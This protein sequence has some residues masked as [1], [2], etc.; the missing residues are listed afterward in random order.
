M[1]DVPSQYVSLLQSAASSSGIPYN[2]VAAQI[3]MESG[4][5][6]NAVSP[7][8][9]QGMAQFEPG[10]WSSYGTGSP[11]TPTNAMAAYAK[12]M[13]TL[14]K[15]EGGS[16]RNALAAYNA[17]PGN[18]PAGYGYADSILSAAG[19]SESATASPGSSAAVSN[20]SGG[21]SSSTSQSSLAGDIFNW[22]T[23]PVKGAIGVATSAGDALTAIGKEFVGV[24]KFFDHLVM[25]ETWIRLGAVM[26]GGILFI[27]GF[28]VLMHADE[29]VESVAGKVA[30]GAA[31]GAI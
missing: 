12:Y 17:G 31:M 2:V 15:Q 26:G 13:G 3:N 23:D 20:T 14:L 24:G 21:T 29:K 25:P 30:S 28:M 16:L 18:L 6:P 10:T 7:T 9:A 4:F 1:T 19:V 27:I 22:I 5:N 11:F 8:G